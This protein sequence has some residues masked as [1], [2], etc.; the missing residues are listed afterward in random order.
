MAPKKVTRK[1]LLKAP[2]EFLTFSERV[3]QWIGDHSQQVTT[4]LLVILALVLLTMGVRWYMGYSH[5][6]AVAAYNR[7]TTGLSSPQPTPQQDQAV[8]KE[9]E[10]L[11]DDHSG[12]KPAR[13]ALLD[14]GRLYFKQ[15][16]YDKALGVY[17]A[18]LDKASAD[19]ARMIPFVKSGLAYT[20]EAKG[21]LAQAA[22]V[23]EEIRKGNAA[24]MNDEALLSL[25]RLY[26]GQNRKDDAR[27]TYQDLIQAMP[28]SAQADIARSKL[29]SIK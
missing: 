7:A 25:A 24:T 5:Q 9:L 26:L 2:D 20:L 28:D 29:A 1:E 16:E 3:F 23:W 8:I 12:A 11:I 4:G 19:D 6:Q 17:Q 15:K 14:L 21:D 13:Y 10:K 27:K 18:W 22:A